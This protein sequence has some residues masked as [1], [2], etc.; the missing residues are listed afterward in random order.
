MVSRPKLV[1]SPEISVDPGPSML[2]I[3]NEVIAISTNSA[4]LTTTSSIA[5]HQ[6]KSPS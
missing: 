5:H 6:S 3:S 4:C 1:I 2:G